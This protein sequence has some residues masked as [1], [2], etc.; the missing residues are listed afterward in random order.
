MLRIEPTQI[1]QA[2]HATVDP[3]VDKEVIAK[4][5]AASPG[6]ASGKILFDPDE[7]VELSKGNGDFILI[8]DETSADDIRGINAAR[9]ILT[10]RGGVTS[11]AA[12]VARGMGKC[13]IVGC[14]DILINP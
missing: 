3:N 11:H 2:L 9:G 12:V 5:L 14:K 8:R 4:G 7:A 10:T 1:E 6:T 13:A